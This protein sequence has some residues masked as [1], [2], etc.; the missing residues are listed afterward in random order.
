MIVNRIKKQLLGNLIIVYIIFP[1]IYI[2]D[3]WFNILTNNYTDGYTEYTNIT[4]FMNRIYNG[5][6]LFSTVLLIG[7]LLPFQIFKNI[8]LYKVNNLFFV[9]SLVLY[10]L[11]N[12]LIILIT[13]Y[14]NLLLIVVP[15]FT[16]KIPFILEVVF[17]SFIIQSFLFF[18]VDKS[19]KVN[20]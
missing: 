6:F 10:T 7:S 2:K 17:F 16:F 20:Y 13:G 14:G 8:Y 4:D 9:K 3:Y 18:L 15:F 1:V 19:F 12:I 5:F 11:I